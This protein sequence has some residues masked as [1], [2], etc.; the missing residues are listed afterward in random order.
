MKDIQDSRENRTEVKLNT[1]P[2]RQQLFKE[3]EAHS[4]TRQCMFNPSS[5]YSRN[6]GCL[7]TKPV[8]REF[9]L[10][11]PVHEGLRADVR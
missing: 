3:F 8:G 11:V 6:T 5:E 4:V 7:K 10:L 1:R 2:Q 9:I